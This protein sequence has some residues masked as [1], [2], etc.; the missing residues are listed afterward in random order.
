MN[1][2]G[3]SAFAVA[4]AA[5]NADVNGAIQNLRNATNIRIQIK[6]IETSTPVGSFKLFGSED[7]AGV[8]ADMRNGTRTALWTQLN[9][10][11]AAVHGSG[12]SAF[13][14]GDDTVDWDGTAPLNL[15]LDLDDPP[16]YLYVMWD[17]SSGGSASTG[18]I[19]VHVGFRGPE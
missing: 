4:G 19:F 17:R 3:I 1:Q 7:K 2:V 18:K 14:D 8:E 10:P 6:G 12:F 9:I 16:A 15:L 11:A 13:T 5:S